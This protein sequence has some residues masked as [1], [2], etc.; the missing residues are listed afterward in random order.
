MSL[1]LHTTL[2]TQPAKHDT[3]TYVA[4][5]KHTLSDP[6]DPDVVLCLVVRQR[7]RA[8]TNA[9]EIEQLRLRNEEI[10]SEALELY[11]EKT[12]CL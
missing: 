6:K 7:I 3:G 2:E 4:H 5:M 9:H 12:K 1:R 10:A 11:R 8:S